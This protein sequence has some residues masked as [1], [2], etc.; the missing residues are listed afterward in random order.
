MRRCTAGRPGPRCSGPAL[1][2]TLNDNITRQFRVGFLVE[3]TPDG[4]NRVTLSTEIHGRS[5][6][7]SA[8]DLLR[9]SPYT[10]RGI[11]AAHQMKDLLFKKM[12]ATDY[13]RV[14]KTIRAGSTSKSMASLSG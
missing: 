1:T 13:T 6:P 11:V 9:P 4:S 3:Q 2:K 12:E 14:A 10:R 7:A 5:G 8:T